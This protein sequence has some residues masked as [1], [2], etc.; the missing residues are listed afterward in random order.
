MKKKL[1]ILSAFMMFATM[2]FSQFE[3]KTNPIGLL[4]GQ[5]PI[6]VEYII[7]DNI[8]VE[9]EAGFN[10][11]NSTLVDADYVGIVSIASFKYYFSPKMGADNIY[12]FPY[13]RFV[14]RSL[15]YNDTDFTGNQTAIGAGFGLGYKW[16]SDKG[17]L[18]DIG[19]GLG[20][21]FSNEM[22]SND[23]TFT[24]TDINFISLN[25]VGRLSI[26]YRF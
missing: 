20:K 13:F 1:M 10:F 12:A 11:G 21:N 8:G 7:N 17:I 18:V 6:A 15:S 25:G 24:D 16:V 19:L 3:V 22:T 4:F 9:V 2:G 14:N 26:G 5:I 23:P